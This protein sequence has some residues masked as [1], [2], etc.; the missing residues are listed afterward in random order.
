LDI[1]EKSRGKEE[2]SRVAIDSVKT[3]QTNEKSYS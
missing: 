1:E 3:V 2:K